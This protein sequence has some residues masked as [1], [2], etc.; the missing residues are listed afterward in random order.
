MEFINNPINNIEWVDVDLL[1]ANDYNPNVVLNQELKLLEFSLIKSGWIQ[2]ILI[3]EEYT[4][5]DGFH[6]C[7]ISKNSDAM[8]RAFGGKV[9]VV[10]MNVSDAERKL[11][12]IR[13]NRAK[14]NHVSVKMHT[15]V[16]SLIDE[17]NYSHD[18]IMQGIGCT[19]DEVVLLYKK[20]VFDH[21]NIKDHKYS[22]A[23]RTPNKKN[24]ANGKATKTTP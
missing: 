9:P 4:I 8:K 3:T 5:I 14:G 22:K 1:N 11:L 19:K 20:G 23:W 15:I 24:R 2:P 13:M 6:R 18:Q 12:T 10:K 16:T 21:L 7:Y 17:H